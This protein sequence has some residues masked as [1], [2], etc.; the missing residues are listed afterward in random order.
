MPYKY[1]AEEAGIDENTFALWMR[2][3]R[4]GRGQHAAFYQAVTRARELGQEPDGPS[5]RR[6][7]GKFGVG[8]DAGAALP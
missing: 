4:E 3:G 5:P 7:Q 1:A 6:R 8:M 2:K